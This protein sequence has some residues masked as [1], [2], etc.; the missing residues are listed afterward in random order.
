MVLLSQVLA[1]DAALGYEE[2]FNIQVHKFNGV[3]VKNLRHLV[4]LVD[5]S[6]EPFL[7][8]DLE[9]DVRRPRWPSSLANSC[10]LILSHSTFLAIINSSRPCSS[11]SFQTLAMLAIHAMPN[12]QFCNK[13]SLPGSC[14]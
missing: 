6:T 14:T 1:C 10:M 5:D 8:F 12:Q 2:L 4:S 7:R 11:L 3:S 13:K 9:Y